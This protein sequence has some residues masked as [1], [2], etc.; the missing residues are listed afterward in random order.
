[1]KSRKLYRRKFRLEYAE[2]MLV[3]FGVLVFVLIAGGLVAA[4]ASYL[5]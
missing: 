5:V 1:M 2:P 3:G 4:I